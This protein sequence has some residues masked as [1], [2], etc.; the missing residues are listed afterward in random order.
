MVGNNSILW[1]NLPK[2]C[3]LDLVEIDVLAMT[4]IKLNNVGLEVPVYDISS[5]SLKKSLLSF[6]GN[7]RFS[8][9]KSG[10][11]SVNVLTALNIE[12]NQGD[13]LAVLGKNGAGKTS[14]LRLLNGVYPPT[15]GNMKLEGE[16][17]SLIDISLG[18]DENATGRENIYLRGALIGMTRKEIVA[19]M[20]AIIEWADIANFIDMPLRTYSSGMQLRLA[21]S[22]ATLIAPEILI[23][24][25]WLSVGDADFAKK[26]EVRMHELVNKSHIFVIATHSEHVAHHFCN[27]AIWMENGKI[28]MDGTSKIV[29]DAYFNSSNP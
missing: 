26:A 13:R 6:A 28:I 7:N 22:I 5:R 18:I 10:N 25:E 27:R 15:E 3:V 12:I 21:F 24:D 4:Q 9:N 20:D 17:S 11:I 2:N 8:F 14:F 23:L 19:E 29:S 16:I 1:K